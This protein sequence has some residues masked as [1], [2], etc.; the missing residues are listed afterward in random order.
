[1]SIQALADSL[2]I[3]ISTVSRALNGYTDVSAATRSRVFDAAKAMNYS[4]HPLAHRLATGKTGAVAILNPLRSGN[5]IDGSAALL[6]TGVVQVL[7]EQK[8]FV[9]SLTLPT[10]E[11]EIPELERLLAARLV[12]AVVL[13]RMRTDDSRVRLLQSRNMPFVTHGRTTAHAPHAWVDIDHLGSTAQATHALI[14]LGHRRIAFLSGMPQMTFAQLREQGFRQAL[15]EANIAP[16]ACPLRSTDLTGAA[17]RQCAAQLLEQSAEQRPTAFVCASDAL[18]LGVIAAVREAGLQV[19]RDISV[20]GHGNTEAGQLSHPP[21]ASVEHDLVQSGRHIAQHVLLLIAGEAA[22]S[23]QHVEEPRL[24]LRAT[25]AQA[26]Q[27]MQAR[28]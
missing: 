25:V 9:L 1:M 13:T 5:A 21:L 22:A 15:A 8:Y 2:G 20:L 27:P 16:N 14:A 19:G 4:P 26:T 10:D 17:G 23:L 11:N 3:S 24:L 28:R 18:A 7:G 6:H 12:D